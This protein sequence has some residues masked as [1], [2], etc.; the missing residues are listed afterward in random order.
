MG[1]LDALGLKFAAPGPRARHAPAAPLSPAAFAPAAQAGE[2]A[3][4]PAQGAAVKGGADVE[5]VTREFAPF[6]TKYG[7]LKVAA[8]L[9][10]VAAAKGGD[11][12]GVGF[13]GALTSKDKSGGRTTGTKKTIAYDAIADRELFAGLALKDLAIGL[14]PEISGL[15]VSVS[16]IFRFTL[17]TN[18]FKAAAQAKLIVLNI[19]GGKEIA[20]PGLEIKVAPVSF[21]YKAGPV[22]AKVYAEYKATFTVDAK[23]VGAAIGKEVIEKVA[24][25]ALK[26]EAERR[27]VK[28]LGR[29]AAEFVLKDL[30]P[31]AAAFGVGLDIGALLNAYTV[32]P[33]VAGMVMDD[34]LGDLNE[35]YQR[36][37]TLGKMWLL[38]KN[39]P[40]IAAA[41][42]AAGVA[43]ATAG[44]AD[45]VLF[46]IMGL[47]KL[48]DFGPAL[49]AFSQGLTELA[50]VARAP[51][52][53]FAG[54]VAHG[55]LVL[56]IKYN[57]KHAIVAH[58]A[59]EPVIAAIFA[60]IRPLYRTRGGLDKLLGVRVKDAKLDAGG[61]MSFAS[62]AHGFGMNWDGQV[63]LTSPATVAAS[64]RAMHIG[65][66]LRFLEAN[67][68][69]R[70]DVSLGDTLDPDEI[71]PKLLDELYG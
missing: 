61:F 60:R 52:E 42:V 31:L 34:I 32:A 2:Q 63:D 30:G 15:D 10:F 1:L 56:G 18:V 19:K 21:P 68:M 4:P 66:F 35:R 23:K 59:L 27:G 8:T 13:A 53:A 55:A 28:L 71:D 43:G 3:A 7:E 48:K 57:P 38:S 29:K 51:G 11:G 17:V 65:A 44:M 58:A 5:V 33:Q 45:V 64:L 26:K 40:R 50:A 69:I 67:R 70:W 22:E 24:K 16:G 49:E 20:G 9:K 37:D 54:A 46:R 12:G 39:S 62:F 47:D 36:A 41:L 14:E 6:R 25:Q